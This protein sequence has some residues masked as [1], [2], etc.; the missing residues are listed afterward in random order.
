MTTDASS[1]R[2]WRRITE[3][4]RAES[5][6]AAALVAA[7]L[8]DANLES[9]L[10]SFLVADESEVEALLGTNLQSLGA[11]MRMAYLL[12]L[13]SVDEMHDL[14]IIK[15]IRNYFAHNLHVSFE[16]SYVQRACGQFRLL[17]RLLGEG[18]VVSHR[19]AL[20]QSTCVLS[21]LLVR[22]RQRVLSRRLQKRPEMT[23]VEF[24]EE[25]PFTQPPTPKGAA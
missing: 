3:E 19:Q 2:D 24:S 6:R 11:R 22:R 15:E 7:A 18:V 12:G 23:H 17:R 8:L 10:R 25:C 4:F 16:D 14:R 21:N 1:Q 9:L 20:E 13:V 5:D